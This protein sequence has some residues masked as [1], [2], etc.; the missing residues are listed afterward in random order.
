MKTSSDK[1]TAGYMYLV[2]LGNLPDQPLEGHL[3]DEQLSA[4]LLLA[5]FTGTLERKRII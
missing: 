3:P 1:A 2:K 4:L 5:N